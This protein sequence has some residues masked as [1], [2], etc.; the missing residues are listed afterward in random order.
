[1]RIQ[2]VGLIVAAITTA[3]ASAKTNP[4][5]VAGEILIRWK[6]PEILQQASVQ[7]KLSDLGLKTLRIHSGGA[8]GLGV[9]R[10]KPDADMSEVLS[11]LK[12][13]GRILYAQPNY[14]MRLVAPLDNHL[15]MSATTQSATR[16][17]IQ[18]RPAEV[19]PPVAD[20]ELKD[21]YHLR[22]TRAFDAWNTTRGSSDMLVAVIDS[23]ID[24]NHP[25]LAFNL[26]RNPSPG[27]EQDLVGFDFLSKNGL[28]WDDDEINGHGTHAS[29]IIGSVGS[30]GLGSSGINQRVSIMALKGF[31]AYG[32]SSTEV[33]VAAIGYAVDHGARIISNSWEGGKKDNPAM[34]EAIERARAHGV[35]MV[36]AAGNSHNDNDNDDTAEYPSGY[37]IDNILSVAATDQEDRLASFSNY[38]KTTVMLGA[39]GVNIFSTL[40]KGKFGWETGTSMACPLVAGAAAMVWSQHPNW[41]YLQVKQALMDSVDPLPTLAGKVYTGGRLNVQKALQMRPA[42]QASGKS[43]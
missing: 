19:L 40:P 3:V 35:L 34:I 38:G 23:G 18:P 10:L 26:W 5:A 1:M 2:F 21:A 28:P 7:Q 36:F 4:E 24:Y 20:P 9:Y 22:L 33:L 31:S 8:A 43:L 12:D 13:D 17:P 25:D 37:H 6:N 14:V 30:N 29:G 39:P 42:A 16:P 41:N 11:E 27:P 15:S 32:F